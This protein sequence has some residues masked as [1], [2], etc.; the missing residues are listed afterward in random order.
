MNTQRKRSPF[1][2]GFDPKNSAR[3][4][5]SSRFFLMAVI[6]I[7]FD[8]EIAIIIIRTSCNKNTNNTQIVEE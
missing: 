7:I 2:C 4:P 3:L 1:E 5:F 8:G 6:F